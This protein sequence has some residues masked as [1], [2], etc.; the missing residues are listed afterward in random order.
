M[1]DFFASVGFPHNGNDDF[2]RLCMW[3]QEEGRIIPT[4]FGTYYCWQIPTEFDCE[5]ELW[6]KLSL[7]GRLSAIKP[8]F[9]HPMEW[10]IELEAALTRAEGRPYD[11]GFRF[12]YDRDFDP[13]SDYVMRTPLVFDCLNF[14]C[15]EG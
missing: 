7:D 2:V 9:L 15:A 4:S 14:D 5:I 8:I 6:L 13:Q 11:G 10:E 3:T 1:S 12:V